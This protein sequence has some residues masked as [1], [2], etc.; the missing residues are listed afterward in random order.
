MR[1]SLARRFDGPASHRFGQ[2]TLLFYDDSSQPKRDD[3]APWFDPTG[4]EQT[5]ISTATVGLRDPTF[6]SGNGKSTRAG[7]GNPNESQP[8]QGSMFANVAVPPRAI[9]D[10]VDAHRH[11]E[12]AT[13]SDHVDHGVSGD[14][15]TLKLPAAVLPIRPRC[16]KGSS[17]RMCAS[18][19]GWI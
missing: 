14:W 15:E 16:A 10:C 19:S 18:K 5:E 9:G 8:I 6:N 17:P 1:R 11:R 4:G 13:G 12:G 3:I 2:E 7:A